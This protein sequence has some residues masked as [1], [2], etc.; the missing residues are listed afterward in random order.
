[1]ELFTPPRPDHSPPEGLN[2]EELARAIDS[3]TRKLRSVRS[4]YRAARLAQLSLLAVIIAVGFTLLWAGPS[5]FMG[6]IFGDGDV[7]TIP[8]LMA[9]WGSV[10]GAAL[11]VGIVSYRLFAHRMNIS[12]GWIHKVHELERRLEHAESEARKRAGQ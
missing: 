5:P 3:L 9:W 8:E 6:R 11:F 2:D 1:M 12:R 10:I 4:S 7:V